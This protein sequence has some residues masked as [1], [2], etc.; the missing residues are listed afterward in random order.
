[1][2]AASKACRF[3]PIS[4]KNRTAPERSFMKLLVENTTEDCTVRREPPI[5]RV[6]LKGY[7]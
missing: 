1:L 6:T 2:L 7:E 4:T 3:E 5:E